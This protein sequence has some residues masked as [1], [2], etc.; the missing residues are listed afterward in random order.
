MPM[1]FDPLHSL[2]NLLRQWGVI[3]GAR[4]T[5]GIVL[6]VILDARRPFVPSVTTVQD[7]LLV[8]R[9]TSSTNTYRI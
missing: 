6:D 3:F 5:F 7:L 1:A 8:V 9:E 4:F 2:N